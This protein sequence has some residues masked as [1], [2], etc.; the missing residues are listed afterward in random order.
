MIDFVRTIPMPLNSRK[1]LIDLLTGKGF[2]LAGA[3]WM[4]TNLTP[5]PS[6]DGR[7]GWTFD[8]DGIADMYKTYEATDLWPLV[9]AT[10]TCVTRNGQ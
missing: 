1:E 3:Q 4:T 9:R 8:I 6:A 5:D 7:L 10:D 2:T